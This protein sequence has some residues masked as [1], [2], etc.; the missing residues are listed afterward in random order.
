M[1][2]LKKLQNQIKELQEQIK[3]KEMQ[4][5]KMEELEMIFNNI[6]EYFKENINNEIY[7]QANDITD[8]YIIVS[9]Q[10]KKM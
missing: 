7:I 10:S 8:K 5:Q 3:Q 9:V 1:L 4:K 6:R 2:T